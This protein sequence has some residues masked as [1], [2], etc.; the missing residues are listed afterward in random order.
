MTVNNH[1]IFCMIVY[2]LISIIMSVHFLLFGKTRYHFLNLYQSL[3]SWITILP[4]R[5]NSSNDLQVFLEYEGIA[6]LRDSYGSLSESNI[7]GSLISTLTSRVENMD[8][9]SS[10]GEI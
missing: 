1:N 4:P 5:D 2:L 3:S 10:V 8:E 7:W 6:G 9:L